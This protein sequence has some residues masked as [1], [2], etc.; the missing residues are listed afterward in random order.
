MTPELQNQIA[1]YVDAEVRR[2]KLPATAYAIIAGG[3]VVMA[4]GLGADAG[5][6]PVTPDTLFQVGSVTKSITAT[7][8]LQLRDQGL[9][10]LDAPVREY[11]PWFQLADESVAKAVTVRHL[12]NQVSAL[13]NG[14]WKIALGDP[15]ITASIEAGVRA[16]GRI[17]PMGAPGKSWMYS[18]INYNILGLLVEVVSGRPYQ[19]YVT[20][21][22]FRP[23]GMAQSTFDYATAGSRPHAPA[24]IKSFGRWVETDPGAGTWCAPSG[25]ALWSSVA[26][27]ARFA[28][29]IMAGTVLAPATAAEAQTGMVAT[30]M[31][32]V[33]YGF[34][35]MV[36]DFHGSR[37]VTHPGTA[38]GHNGMLA[39]LPDE[40][41]AVAVLCSD[42]AQESEAIG[43]GIL[44]MLKGLS[45][46]G[47]TIM[48]DFGGVF[49]AIYW[50]MVAVA[51]LLVAGLVLRAPAGPMGLT[52]AVLWTA[53]AALL[54]LIP[55][56]VR[57]SQMLPLP[58]PLNVGAGGWGVQPVVSWWAFQ[59]SVTAWAAFGWVGVFGA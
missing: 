35:W 16:S 30:M 58:V 1:A 6:G 10:N 50:G 29:A 25:L 47:K 36:T 46:A 11:L 8:V 17:K 24:Y 38:T 52:G 5:G 55:P 39:L 59:L 2:R 48:P 26:D 37:M 14:A 27:L 43:L 22:I 13:P 40:Q 44:R 49:A 20:E 7:A 28:E 57:R 51:A 18:N 56:A 15:A 42:G 12:L 9:I 53:F 4:R 41:V 19:E 31:S 45:P 21:E 54:A 32:G 23:L 33:R 34:G 3:R